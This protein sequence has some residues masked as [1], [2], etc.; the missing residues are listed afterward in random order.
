MDRQ[1]TVITQTVELHFLN[2]PHEV[3]RFPGL[4]S[5]HRG[6]FFRY[7]GEGA[8]DVARLVDV[9]QD[10]PTSTSSPEEMCRGMRIVY[11]EDY[12]PQLAAKYVQDF[13]NTSDAGPFDGLLGFSEG[14]CVAAN[15]L[16]DQE[17]TSPERPFKC[18]VFF[19]GI[20]PA[21]AGNAGIYLADECGQVI[22]TPTLHVF[23]ARDPGKFASL[24]LGNLCTS[25]NSLVYDH[26]QGH[27][28]PRAPAITKR[29]ATL[30]REMVASIESNPTNSV[31]EGACKS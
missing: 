26:G 13:A 17:R 5:Q 19:N 20:P 1:Q 3:S 18:A 7:L 22:K 27:E 28:I 15:I 14:A 6:P 31:N 21:R 25:D 9:M 8:P 30:V 10:L 29:I 16:L 23:G 24:A 4:G 2:G 12:K 11:G